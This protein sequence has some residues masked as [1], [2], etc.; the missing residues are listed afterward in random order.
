MQTVLLIGIPGSGKSTFYRERFS[1]SHIRINL[2]MLK[3]RQ[4]EMILVQACLDA[5]QP[6]VV[7]NTNVNAAERARYIPLARQAGF[8]VIGYY[9]LSS[10]AE[11]LERNSHRSGKG[12]IPDSGV[13]ARYR[14]L[15]PP[16]LA[17][18]FDRLYTVRI[19]PATRRFFVAESKH[20][21]L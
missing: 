16:T 9:F 13:R 14:K 4:R 17:E 12:R 21:T 10:L 1:D 6:F 5:R 20:G 11:A 18:G 2:D 8:E 7:D 19:D 15:Q 3:T